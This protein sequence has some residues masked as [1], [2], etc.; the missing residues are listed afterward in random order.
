[1]ISEKKSK[2][3]VF[4]MPLHHIGRNAHGFFTLGLKARG[5]FSMGLFSTGVFSFGV[6]SLGLVAGGAFAI[7]VLSAGAFSVGLLAI[8]AI[9]LGLVAIGAVSIGCFSQGALAIGKYLAMGDEARGMIVLAKSNASGTLFSTTGPL[10]V[11]DA[12]TVKQLLQ[13]HVPGWLSWAVQW[14]HP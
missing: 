7:G 4:G 14:L 6:L 8:G 10:T 3:T 5:M 9:C 1:M 13:T 12:E 2:R 11:N